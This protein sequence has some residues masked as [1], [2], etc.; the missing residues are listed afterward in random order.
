VVVGSVVVENGKG[1][2]TVGS[3]FVTGT[4]TVGRQGTV[5]VGFGVV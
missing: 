5:T 4:G 3:V 1:D 2:F